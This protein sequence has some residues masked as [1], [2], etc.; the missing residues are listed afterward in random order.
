M[1]KTIKTALLAIITM[2]LFTAVPAFSFA[3]NVTWTD[4]FVQDQPPN[5]E[6]CQA[7]HDFLNQLEPDKEFTSVTMSSTFA[8]EGITIT[9]PIAVQELAYLLYSR[10]PGSIFSDGHT[11][12]VYIGCNL[13]SCVAS[14]EGVELRIDQ[15]DGCRCA[16]TD[17]TVRPDIGNYNWGGVN[18]PTCS[19]PDQ[20]MMV[21]FLIQNSDSD[22]DDVN[23]D[24]DMCPESDLSPTI[25]TDGCDSGVDNILFATGCSVNDQI[26]ECAANAKNHGSFVSC[27]SDILNLLKQE[28]LISGKEKGATQKCAAKANLP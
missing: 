20:T 4:N 27:T 28:G 11:W 12:S 18:T 1:Q 2:A 23:D 25:M 19:S 5:L 6:Q 16:T 22:G 14:G 3:E 7:W 8:P 21:E 13:D 10:T 9:D 17:Y 24:I 15:E 26:A